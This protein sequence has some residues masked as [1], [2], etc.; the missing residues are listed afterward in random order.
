M[1]R[2]AKQAVFFMLTFWAQGAFAATVLQ[3][4]MQDL[5]ERSVFIFEG[6]VQEMLMRPNGMGVAHTYIKFQVLDVLKGNP[7]VETPLVLSFLGGR[8]GGAVL[9][10]V[11]QSRIEPGEHGV[12][13]VESLD[14]PQVNPFVGEDQGRFVIKDGKVYTAQGLRVGDIKRVSAPA[15]VMASRLV[16]TGVETNEGGGAMPLGAFKEKIRGFLQE[17]PSGTHQ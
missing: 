5:L 8:L 2:T 17:M 7:H 10:V 13:F 16:A 14:K 4:G 3:L 12:Y 15:V 11:G 1:G 9:Q 6:R